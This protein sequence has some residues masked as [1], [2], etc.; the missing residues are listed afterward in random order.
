MQLTN[1][2]FKAR[3][4]DIDATEQKLQQLSPIYKGQDHQIDTYFNVPSGRLKLRE[5]TIENALTQITQ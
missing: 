4:N 5:G 3:V 2:E 1:F